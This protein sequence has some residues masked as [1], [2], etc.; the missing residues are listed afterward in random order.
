MAEIRTAVLEAYG[1]GVYRSVAALIFAVVGTLVTGAILDIDWGT[2][3]FA[4][5]SSYAEATRR[6]LAGESPY[7]P[8]QMVPYSLVDVAHGGG[9]VYPPTA[10]PL[11]AWTI[12]VPPLLGTVGM[13]AVLLY[14]GLSMTVGWTR[15]LAVA[16]LGFSPLAWDAIY[17]GQVTPLIAAAFGALWLTGRSEWAALAGMVKVFPFVGLPWGRTILH[18][19]A[20]TALVAAS[21]TVVLGADEWVRFGA[22]WSNAEALCQAPSWGSF[23]CLGV[24]WLGWAVAALMVVAAVVRRD[25][26][27]FA[28]LGIGAVM[29]SPDIYPN[30]MLIVAVCALPIIGRLSARRRPEGVGDAPTPNLDG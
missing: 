7:T 12:V 16:V 21:V 13:T 2:W 22:A 15:I 24:P 26:V 11:L 3:T 5:Y 9:F 4:D 29:P 27:G 10:I 28:L 25:E 6:A 17:V 8:M 23:E 1:T 18:A 19:A 20:L 30:Y 14:V